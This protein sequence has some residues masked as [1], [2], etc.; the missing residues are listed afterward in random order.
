MLQNSHALRPARIMQLKERLNDE[1]SRSGE[2]LRINLDKI[3]KWLRFACVCACFGAGKRVHYVR[4]AWCSE[5]SVYTPKYIKWERNNVQLLS[6]S[7]NY[8]YLRVSG[9]VSTMEMACPAI[10]MQWE[11]RWN[12]EIYLTGEKQLINLDKIDEWLRFAC[13]WA[14]F[15][16]GKRVHYVL[17][18]W[19]SENIV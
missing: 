5:K 2:K 18:A 16:A 9:L 6:K 1:I 19:C 15:E 12:V 3:D 4:H 10:C 17:H 14:R 11:V 8:C 7:P 13:V